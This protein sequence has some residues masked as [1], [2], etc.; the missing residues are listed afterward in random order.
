M[1]DSNTVIALFTYGGGMR[2]LVPAHFMSRIE[3]VTGLRMAEMVDIFTGPSTGAILN[4]ALNV[5]HPDD[6][7]VP[8]YRARQ[9]IK[10]YEREGIHIFP[11]DRF[12]DF[13][14]MIHDFNNRTMKI[15]KLKSLMRQGHYPTTHL[16]HSLRA[17]YGDLKLSD[18]LKSL[19]VPV[20]NL[21]SG[22]MKVLKETGETDDAPVHTKNNL[23]DQGGHAVWLKNMK[24]GINRKPTPDVSLY[25]AVLASC[26]A[27]TF[28]PCHH[29]PVKYADRK[30]KIELAGIDG[31][32]FDNP[33]ISYHGAIRQHLPPNTRLIMIVLGTGHM[34]RSFSKDDWNRYGGLGVV[35]PVNDLPL[36]NILFHASETALLESFS[37]EM[38][39]DVFV[40]NRSLIAKEDQPDAPS[41]DI[42][43]ASAGNIKNLYHFFEETLEE[44]KKQFDSICD[45][46]VRNRD[47]RQKDDGGFFKN[48]KKKIGG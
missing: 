15:G 35:D 44:N 23:V 47:N 26:A 29:F 5:P 20:Y 2:G 27:P 37:Q 33:C 1:S 16:S 31:S 17:L 18:T 9:M 6:P 42:D 38:G 43:D 32:I 24:T 4:A 7:N 34:A 12:R 13:R 36:I 25:D 19:V 8:K 3:D 30:D 40:F 39:D 10:F 11:R 28:F 48:L 14:G 21:E 46:L 22:K 45:L 41:V